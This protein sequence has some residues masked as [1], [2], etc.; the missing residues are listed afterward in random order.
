M[1]KLHWN[2][3]GSFAMLMIG[4]IDSERA[5]HS[6]NAE[7]IGLILSWRVLAA[8]LKFICFLPLI[9]AFGF[10]SSYIPFYVFG[11]IVPDS[12]TLQGDTYVGVL[13]ALVVLVVT[14]VSV[15]GV[16]LFSYASSVRIT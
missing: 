9:F 15:P 1:C 11:T 2:C 12:L 4:N 8:D 3:Q 5:D 13:S 6:V 16:L 7:L 10:S 14:G